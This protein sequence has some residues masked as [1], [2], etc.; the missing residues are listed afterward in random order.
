[1]EVEYSRVDEVGNLDHLL[2]FVFLRCCLTGHR[3]GCFWW[4][5][6]EGAIM[7]LFR[8]LDTHEYIAFAMNGIQC[9][10]SSTHKQM[11]ARVFRGLF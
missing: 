6:E 9:F 11:V 10:C 7:T 8:S 5:G 2:V 1:M 4:N 3:S